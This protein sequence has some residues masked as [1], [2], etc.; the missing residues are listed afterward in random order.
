MENKNLNIF[1]KLTLIRTY[2]A[3]CLMSAIVIVNVIET[4]AKMA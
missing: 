2:N 4:N 3:Q 1:K